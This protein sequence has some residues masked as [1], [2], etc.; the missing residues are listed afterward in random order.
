[1]TLITYADE[2]EFDTSIAAALVNFSMLISFALMWILV[3]IFQMA[4]M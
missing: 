3:W 1:M 2:L 4:P